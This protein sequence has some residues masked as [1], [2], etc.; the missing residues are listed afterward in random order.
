MSIA[1]LTTGTRQRFRRRGLSRQERAEASW[2]YLLIA[3]VM[4]GF[5]VFFLV[6]LGA[7]L[8]LSFTTWTMLD[9]PVWVGIDNYRAV[10]QDGE[11]RTALWNTVA[12]TVP[13]V[14]LRLVVALAL[15]VAL[16]SNIRFRTFYRILFFMPVLTMPVAIGTIWKWLYDPAFGPINSALGQL[17]LPQPEWLSQPRTAVIAVVIVLLWSG[18]G[19]DMIIYLAG[20]QAIP[21]DYYDA[22][23]LDGAGGWQQFRDITLPL[24]T[25]TTFFLSVIGIIYS[26]QVF[27]LVY[28]M[29][30]ID[31][32][33]VLP[34][35]VYYIYE[36]GF[37]SFRM[38]YAITVAWVLLAIILV[39]TLIQFRLQ[40][41]WVHYA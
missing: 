36:E 9:S 32:T 11:F 41:R 31:Q 4:I 38:G 30:R 29:T 26:L 21:R 33:N 5:T 1:E 12:I 15:A 28:V 40:R 3:P 18:L 22:A 34:T 37:R 17:G 24:L 14:T 27:D 19:Y 35:V 8:V 16:N 6:A 7:S 39:F 25:P 23:A 2:A 10:L 13:H 20:L